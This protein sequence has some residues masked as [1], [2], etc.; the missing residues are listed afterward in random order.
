MTVAVWGDSFL[1]MFLDF[2]LPSYL[3]P[4]GIPE[5]QRRGYTSVFWLYTKRAFVKTITAHSQYRRLSEVVKVEIVCID[6]QTDISGHQNVYETMNACHLDFISRSELSRAAMVFF[7]PDAF[8]SS[9]SLRYTLDQVESGKR[10]ILIAGVRANK[11]AVLAEL[12]PLKAEILEQGLT[13]R[14]LVSLLMKYPHR[15]TETLTWSSEQFDIGWA[16]HLYWPVNGDGYLARCFHLHTFFVFPRLEARPEVAHDFDWLAK[17]GLEPD[18]IA[19]V[20]DSDQICALE[21]SAQDRGVNGRIGQRTIPALADWTRRYAAADHRLY[22]RNAICFHVGSK[23][24][25]EWLKVKLFSGLAVDLILLMAKV[26]SW[27]HIELL[28]DGKWRCT[29]SLSSKIQGLLARASDR[30]RRSR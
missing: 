2:V 7:S 30:F 22:V 17:I 12:M 3:A 4:G 21:L 26:Q 1:E 8:W 20:R 5:L 10:A 29:T 23:E 25:M 19:I 9:D 16:S 28:S 15:I 11:E 14:K 13:G 18:E 27:L 24:G 6:E